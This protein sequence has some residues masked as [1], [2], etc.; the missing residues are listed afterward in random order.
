MC[1]ARGDDSTVGIRVKSV[2]EERSSALPY[3]PGIDGLRAVAVLAVLGF[4]LEVAGFDGGFLG[5]SLFFTLSG[6]LITQLI[7]REHDA[8]DGVSLP[9]FWGRRFRRLMPAALTTLALV[10]TMSLTTE[11]FDGR[12]LRGDLLAGVGYAA[13]WRFATGSQSYTDLFTSA[14]SPIQHFW[15]LAI[16]EQF[17]FVFPVVM[18]VLLWFGS[19]TAHRHRPAVV[20]LIGLLAASVVASLVTDSEDLIYYGTHTRAAELIVGA[21]LAFVLPIGREVSKAVARMLAILGGAAM[22]V[23]VVL[24]MASGSSDGWLYDGGLAVFATVSAALVAG[25]LAPG[26]LRAVLGW[27]PLVAIGRISYGVYVFHWPVI[28]ALDEDRIDLD[29][30]RLNLVRTIVTFVLAAASARWIEN[31]IRRRRV[32]TEPRSAATSGVAALLGVTLLVVPVSS[33]AVSMPT[34]IDAP[35]EVVAFGDSSPEPQAARADVVAVEDSLRIVVVGSVEGAADEISAAIP[36]DVR[37]EVVDFS[38]PGCSIRPAG[39]VLDGCRPL[40]SIVDEMSGGSRPD[41]VVLA[42]GGPERVLLRGLIGKDRPSAMLEHPELVQRRFRVVSEYAGDL[43]SPF[44]TVPLLI[45]DSSVADGL[46]GELA[47]IDAR[48]ESVSLLERPEAQEMRD[49][50][51]LMINGIEGLDERTRVMVIGDSTSYG[52]ASAINAAAGERFDV[53]WAGGRNCPIVDAVS[54]RWWP[55]MA[56]DVSTCPTMDSTWQSLFAEFEPEFLLVVAS[57]PEQSEQRYEIDGEWYSVDDDEFT[58]RHLDAMEELMAAAQ[59]HGTKVI[60]FD[61]PAITSGSFEGADFA[62]RRRVRGWNRLID[63]FAER[64]PQITVF[65]WSSIVEE[66]ETANG[67]RAGSLREDGVHMALDALTLLA[68]TDVIPVLTEVQSTDADAG[69]SD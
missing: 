40:N 38:Q 67:G 29:G 22:V 35:D 52:I 64:W 19:K 25:A 33:G 49:G 3:V 41:L 14:P 51:A 31:P 6:Y 54:V 69:T 66:A 23:F 1:A 21:L 62:D 61:S 8:E 47:D 28:V 15:S 58:S 48:L 34:G 2:G 43:T 13:N 7:L 24:V 60:V 37:A 18:A 59:T 26:P 20:A 44:L 46:Q 50:L 10:A 11:V 39:E 12:R 57:V 9:R 36:A 17:Y 45:W 68:A 5:V 27:S 65:G 42:I 4:H 56:F 16:E 63:D 32:L 30:W 53:L 55:D